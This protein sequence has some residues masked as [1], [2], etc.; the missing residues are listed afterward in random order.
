VPDNGPRTLVEMEER[1]GQ[2]RVL[3]LRTG[4]EA[5]VDRVDAVLGPVLRHIDRIREGVLFMTPGVVREMIASLREA[6]ELLR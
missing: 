2:L 1:V 5:L 4:G 6:E 3:A